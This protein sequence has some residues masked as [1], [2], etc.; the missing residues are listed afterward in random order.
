MAEGE[1][2]DFKEAQYPLTSDAEKAELI[3][4]VLA[5]ANGWRTADAYILIGVREVSGDRGVV[6]GVSGPLVEANLQQMVNVILSP[7]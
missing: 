4:D 2:L 5:F 3:K 1:T 7:N 6:T